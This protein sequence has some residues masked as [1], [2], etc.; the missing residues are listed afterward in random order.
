[1]AAA[2]AAMLCPKPGTCTLLDGE[3][4]E[5]PPGSGRNVYLVFDAIT[6]CDD[7]VGDGPLSKRLQCIG[8][9]VR[10]PYKQEEARRRNEKLPPLPVSALQCSAM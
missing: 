7:R 5:S 8:H 1:V 6:Y 2:Y 4:V 10:V 3:L 9:R